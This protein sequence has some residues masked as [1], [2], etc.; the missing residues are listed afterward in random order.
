MSWNAKLA[1]LFQKHGNWIFL[2]RNAGNCS[3]YP[4]ER[5]VYISLSIVPKI[6]K[7]W[8][9]PTEPITDFPPHP[10]SI[11]KWWSPGVLSEWKTSGEFPKSQDGRWVELTNLQG[12]AA[13]YEATEGAVERTYFMMTNPVKK[14]SEKQKKNLY[15]SDNFD[16]L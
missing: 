8:E 7:T 11:F 1:K 6:Y 9:T 4:C 16:L 13:C 12:K 15:S 2:M 10:I 5:V 3:K 14:K